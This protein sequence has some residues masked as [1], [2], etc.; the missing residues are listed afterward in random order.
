MD[1]LKILSLAVVIYVCITFLISFAVQMKLLKETGK[2]DL[3]LQTILA[4][5]ALAFYIVFYG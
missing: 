3:T 5:I 4:S 1:W 2:I